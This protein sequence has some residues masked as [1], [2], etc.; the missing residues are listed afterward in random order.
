M[1]LPP[2]FVFSQSSLQDYADCPRRFE[3][4]YLLKIQW[5][6]LESEPVLEREHHAELGHQFHQMIHQSIIGIP[7]SMITRQISDSDLLFW[8]QQ[9][10]LY[11]P[12][13]ELPSRRLPEFTLSASL[14]HYRILA[15]YDL[16]SI[17]PG[18]KIIIV[19][20]KTSHKKPSMKNLH[21]RLQSRLYPFLIVYAGQALQDNI[22]V[23][24]DQVEMMYWFTNEP[25]QPIRFIYDQAQYEED[26]ETIT[27]MISEIINP[28]GNVFWMT[29]D[30]KKCQFCVYRSFCNRGIQAGD[31]NETEESIETLENMPIQIDFDQIGEIAF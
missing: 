2:D 31:W 8:W 13:P 16:L 6:A 11:N 28:T 12:I 20:W 29:E 30:E 18:K 3:L 23:K 21:N 22:P 10:L 15:K 19:D 17:D 5:P 9:F 26:K 25:E 27:K 4:R 7:E 24:S 1:T 14:N